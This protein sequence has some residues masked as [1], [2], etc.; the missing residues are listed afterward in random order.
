MKTLFKILRTLFLV[1][2]F[3]IGLCLPTLTGGIATII[4][5]LVLYIIFT[6]IRHAKTD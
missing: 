5:T 4:S 6:S 3:S 1:I 2:G